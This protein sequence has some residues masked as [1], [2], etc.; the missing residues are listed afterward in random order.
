LYLKETKP[1]ENTHTHT[2][3]QCFPLMHLTAW[4]FFFFHVSDHL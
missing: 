2:H 1:N 3:T 4:Q